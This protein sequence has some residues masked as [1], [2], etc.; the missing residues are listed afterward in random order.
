MIEN[1]KSVLRFYRG[2][3]KIIQN[4]LIDVNYNDIIAKSN[5]IKELLKP[6]GKT[7]NDMVV[8]ARFSQAPENEENHIITYYVD[9]D[10]I[11]NTIKELEI[12]YRFINEKLNGQATPD[13]FNESN[14]LNYDGYGISMTKLRDIVIDCSVVD[15]FAV[16]NI[17]DIPE[18]DSFLVTFYKTEISISTILEKLKIDEM[19]Y[20]VYRG[21]NCVD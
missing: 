5:R 21:D 13:N 17:T 6:K 18:Q 4:I 14:R 20:N 2:I 11:N 9:V 10:T 15:S 12:A 16:P 8:G 1:L 7:T 3:D 19:K